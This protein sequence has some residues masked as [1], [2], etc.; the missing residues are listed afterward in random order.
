MTIERIHYDFTI[1]V[2]TSH[3][4]VVIPQ[5]I[6]RESQVSVR[7]LFNL[8]QLAF[9]LVGVEQFA[10]DLDARAVAKELA[11]GKQIAPQRHAV[12]DGA[13]VVAYFWEPL[14]RHHVERFPLGQLLLKPRLNLGVVVILGPGC[15]VSPDPF[16]LSALPRFQGLDDALFVNHREKLFA[17]VAGLGLAFDLIAVDH[18]AAIG[19]GTCP[20]AA[21]HCTVRLLLGG[22]DDLKRTGA[23]LRSWP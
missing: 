14:A 1:D 16:I 9:R 18:P 2:P 8:C 22:F 12:L 4:R 7:R 15:P 17:H 10:K 21:R 6:Q 3:T 5:L 20:V 23:A 19:I 11:R 13:V